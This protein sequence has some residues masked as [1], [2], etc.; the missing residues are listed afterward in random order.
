MPAEREAPCLPESMPSPPASTPINSTPGSS[1]KAVKVPIAFEPPPTQAITRA[2]NESSTS[3][4]LQA[5]LVA[6]HALEV[7]DERRIR[8]RPRGCPE[9]VVGRPHVRHPVADCG[10][11]GLLQSLEPGLDRFHG[12]AKELHPLDV[13]RLSAHVLGAH[14]DDALEVEQSACDSG[15][16]TVLAGARLGDHPRLAHPLCEECLADRVVDLVRARVGQVLAL[17][18]DAAAHPL[19]KPVGAIERRRPPDEVAQ[20]A[21]ELGPE[22]PRPSRAS[23]QAAESSS[24][25]SINTSGTKRP[26]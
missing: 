15:R 26:P 10:A 3:S 22:R 12:G 23:T 13:R 24:R 21:L 18:I 20:Q 1:R 4:E 16:D 9:Y 2:G 17:E 8:R 7:A 14:V 5:R 11:D 25:A 19:G 6:D